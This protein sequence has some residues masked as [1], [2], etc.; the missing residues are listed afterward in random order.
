MQH[1]SGL[2]D[3]GAYLNLLEGMVPVAQV[4]GPQ[5]SAETQPLLLVPCTHPP[6]GLPPP[7]SSA[8]AA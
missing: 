3:T 8:L 2:F 1:A 5:Q 6:L 7:A 4:P